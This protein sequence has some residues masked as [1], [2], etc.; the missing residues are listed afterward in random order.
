MMGI[1]DLFR[2]K[3]LEARSSGTGY[4]AQLIGA[5]QS[6]IAGV[7]GIGELTATVQG[8]VSLWKG[9]PSLAAVEGPPLS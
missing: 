7:S 9:G 4:T 2:R 8:C 6:Y 3:P 1:L 5:R